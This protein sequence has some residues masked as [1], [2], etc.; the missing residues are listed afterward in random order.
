M[1]LLFREKSPETT[2]PDDFARIFI[3]PSSLSVEFRFVVSSENT[4]H[5]GAGIQAKTLSFRPQT[6]RDEGCNV[7]KPQR[8]PFSFMVE[9]LGF[10]SIQ[11]SVRKVSYTRSD[12]FSSVAGSGS[13]YVNISDK[14]KLTIFFNPTITQTRAI[15]VECNPD[16]GTPHSTKAPPAAAVDSSRKATPMDPKA[17]RV[18]AEGIPARGLSAKRKLTCGSRSKHI[19][20]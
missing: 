3:I 1:S 2:H 7:V 19:R 6:T 17:M 12:S 8:S 9:R 15:N 13:T 14:S 20:R 5:L 16:T 10:V 18:C 4:A 11:D